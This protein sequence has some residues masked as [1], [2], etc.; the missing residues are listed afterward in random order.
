MKTTLILLG[1]PLCPIC[2]LAS[3]LLTNLENQ[4][5]ILRVNILSFFSKN[6]PVGIL[7]MRTYGLVNGLTTFFGNEN[8]LLLKYDPE[9]EEMGYVPFK[10]FIVVG[11]LNSEYVDYD[12]LRYE[13][14]KSPYGEWPPTNK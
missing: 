10:K 13:I 8:V 3:N 12:E 1:K 4:Y 7:G 5:D 14:E 11:Q 2:E 6:G 9:T